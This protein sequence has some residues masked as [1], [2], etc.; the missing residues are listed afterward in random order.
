M[1]SYVH[2]FLGNLIENLFLVY[3]NKLSIAE[4]GCQKRGGIENSTNHLRDHVPRIVE[5][6]ELRE[7]SRN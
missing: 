2:I 3:F 4:E 5:T 7:R 6:I 1:D